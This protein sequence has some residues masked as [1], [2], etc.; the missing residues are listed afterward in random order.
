MQQ[1]MSPLQEA[2]PSL[3]SLKPEKLMRTQT[4]KKPFNESSKE[5]RDTLVGSLDSTAILFP[6]S[7]DKNIFIDEK[8]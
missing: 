2:G 1:S 8:K 5:G 3:I 6:I 4:L 7:K